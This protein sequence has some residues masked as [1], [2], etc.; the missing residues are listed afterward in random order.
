MANAAKTIA[1]VIPV[2]HEEKNIIEVLRRIEHVNLPELCLYLIADYQDDP[3]LRLVDEFRKTSSLAIQ[4]LVQKNSRGPASALKLGITSSTE[5]YI[6]F[7]T[8]DNSD[9]PADIPALVE[10][11]KQGYSLAC[12]SRYSPD[13][14]HVGGPK[15]KHFLSRMAG[16]LSFYVL[17]AGTVDPTNLFKAVSR[18]FIESIEIDS[19]YGFTLGLELVTKVQ[20]QNR[21]HLKDIPTVW[22]ERSFGKSHF[23]ITRW[24]PSYV[25]WFYRL[26]CACLYKLMKKAIPRRGFCADDTTR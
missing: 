15:L 24:L 13:G 26:L 4:I 14:A 7:L 19:K 21:L 2:Y 11:L 3:T 9:N 12:A 23:D 8:G 6:V 25:Y 17:R 10:V 18:D 16:R 1:L 20:S 5:R 22:I